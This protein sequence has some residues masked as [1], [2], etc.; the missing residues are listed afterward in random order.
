MSTARAKIFWKILLLSTGVLM[1]FFL[2]NPVFWIPPDLLIVHIKQFLLA[3]SGYLHSEEAIDVFQI[4]TLRFF[5]SLPNTFF[6]S[7]IAILILRKTE[8]RRLL[9]YSTLLW[10]LLMHCAYWFVMAV[11]KLGAIKAGSTFDPKYS[12][13]GI[14]FQYQA[15]QIVA[16]YSVFFLGVIAGSLLFKLSPKVNSASTDQLT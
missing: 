12:P 2:W 15:V 1:G 4:A 10:P 11:L 3:G 14:R 6:I 5:T 9:L 16:T 13:F 8:N 7:L